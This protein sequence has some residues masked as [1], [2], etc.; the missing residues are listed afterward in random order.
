MRRPAQYGAYGHP[1]SALNARLYDTAELIRAGQLQPAGVA[2]AE[3][4][5]LAPKN[6]GVWALVSEFELKRGNL[7]AAVDASREALALL[8]G[9]AQR[10]V[11]LARCLAYANQLGE[12]ERAV[13][14]ALAAGVSAPDHLTLLGSVLVRCEAYEQALALYDQALEVSAGF[15]EA[16]RGQIAVYRFLGRL[17]EAERL[18]DQFLVSRPDDIEMVHLRSNLRTQ[19]PEH[20]HVDQL[21]AMLASDIPHWRARVQLHYALAKELEDLEQFE[22]SFDELERG[23]NLR[24]SHT[25]YDVA[26]DVEIFHAIKQAFT[27]DRIAHLSGKGHPNAE[28]IFIVGM[29]RS[30]TTLVERIIASHDDVFAAGELQDFATEMIAAAQ[31]AHG[32]LS[33]RRLDLPS[34]ALTADLEKLG[35]NYIASTRRI[36]GHTRRFTDKMPLNFLYIGFIRLAL[37]NARIVHVRRDPMDSCYAMYKYLFK[38]AYPFS[39]DQESLGHYF[40]AYRDLMEFWKATFPNQ[41]IEIEYE[42]LTADQEGESRRLIAELGLEWQAACLNFHTNSAASTTG[43]ASQIRKPIYRSSVAKWRRF[44]T[45]LEP[46]RRVLADGGIF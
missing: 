29:P 21:Y 14:A 18:C 42:R 33:L 31:M 37:P 8:P 9:S 32:T 45:R 34:L 28:P 7:P 30:G 6:S 2:I 25:V 27:P 44:E 11:Q 10:H 1:R 19:S 43:S 36:T 24:R 15:S 5:K 39:Y 12:A 22:K 17:E 38:H 13:E 4:V 46:L 23:A 3:L 20:N 40:L 16:Q 26:R 35:E 41:I